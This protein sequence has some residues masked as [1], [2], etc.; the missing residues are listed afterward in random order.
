ME[1]SPSPDIEMTFVCGIKIKYTS[2]ESTLHK[3]DD[4]YQ[5]DC[6]EKIPEHLLPYIDQAKIYKSYSTQLETLLEGVEAQLNI[7][8][9]F[10]VTFGTVHSKFKEKDIQ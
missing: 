7:P 6:P 3:G 1:N 5:L 4:K 8:P 10:P 9:L 2:Q